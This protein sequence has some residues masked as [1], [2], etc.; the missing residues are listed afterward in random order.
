M[1]K[2]TEEDIKKL[3]NLMSDLVEEYTDSGYSI[4][5]LDIVATKDGGWDASVSVGETNNML[6]LCRK[7]EPTGRYE[8]KIWL[9]REKYTLIKSLEEE[10][11]ALLEGE[12]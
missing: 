5:K 9:Q 6:E 10:Y 4:I 1:L 2:Y 8:E 12:S 11:R 7:W 3:D